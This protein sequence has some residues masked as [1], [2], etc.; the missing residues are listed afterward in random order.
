MLA[1]IRAEKPMLLCVA[2]AR[3]DSVQEW[4]C[5]LIKGDHVKGQ[6]IGGEL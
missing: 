6:N 5:Q 3:V 2:V 4:S 1:T